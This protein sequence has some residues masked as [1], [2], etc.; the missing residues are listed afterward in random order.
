VSF[1][2]VDIIT[3]TFWIL[4]PFFMIIFAFSGNSTSAILDGTATL[5]LLKL[6]EDYT[7]TMPY[8]HVKGIICKTFR[9]MSILSEYFCVQK[10]VVMYFILYKK[11][12]N[13]F[14][15]LVPSP[16]QKSQF[17]VCVML[18]LHGTIFSCAYNA[19]CCLT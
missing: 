9:S 1:S 16:F 19:I 8:A 15:P 12:N 2:V 7:V 5:T 11:R 17:F 6:G 18:R 10:F 3:R 13:K 14:N 4:N